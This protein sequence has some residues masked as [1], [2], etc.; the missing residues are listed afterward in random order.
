MRGCN[1]WD[2][3]KKITKQKS[4]MLFTYQSNIGTQNKI[5][6]YAHT[7]T[8]THLHKNTHMFAWTQTVHTSHEDNAHTHTSNWT[9]IKKK[10]PST[11]KKWNEN[12]HHEG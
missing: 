3:L 11:W 10:T 2:H 7:L 1:W 4:R 5:N 9:F 8:H 6:V 12:S